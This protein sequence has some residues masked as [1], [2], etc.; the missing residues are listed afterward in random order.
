MMHLGSGGTALP[1]IEPLFPIA[2]HNTRPKQREKWFH[3]SDNIF[4][5]VTQVVTHDLNNKE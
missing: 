5:K 4:M 2:C 1:L 3:Y